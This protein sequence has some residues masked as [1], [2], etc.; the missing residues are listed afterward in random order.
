LIES[1]TNNLSLFWSLGT[2]GKKRDLRWKSGFFGWDILQ[3][4]RQTVRMFLVE[5]LPLD[6]NFGLPCSFFLQHLL[7]SFENLL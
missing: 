7:Y 4:P 2:A 3:Q 6:G 1:S 5:I